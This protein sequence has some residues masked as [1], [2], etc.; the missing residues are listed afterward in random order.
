[1][2]NSTK[3]SMT[4]KDALTISISILALTVS[5]LTFYFTNVKEIDLLYARVIGYDYQ[6]TNSFN[7]DS[8]RFRIA[9]INSGNRDAICFEPSYAVGDSGPIGEGLYSSRTPISYS[10]PTL[11]HSHEIKVIDLQIP[12]DF[13]RIKWGKVIDSSANG[14]IENES[15]C[16]IRFEAIDSK[17]KIHKGTLNLKFLI[18]HNAKDSTSK[19]EWFDVQTMENSPDLNTTKVIIIKN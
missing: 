16:K 12:L 9:L 1:M 6:G 2:N 7:N 8:L 11:V 14:I 15:I 18:R 13:I 5:C 3:S 10:I 17:S 4:V 19:F